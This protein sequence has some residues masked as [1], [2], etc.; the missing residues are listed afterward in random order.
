MAVNLCESIDQYLGLSGFF[1][2]GEVDQAV[3]FGFFNFDTK[4]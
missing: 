1:K 4:S 3:K 2:V